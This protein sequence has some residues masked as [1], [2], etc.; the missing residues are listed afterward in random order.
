VSPFLAL[1]VVPA[2]LSAASRDLPDMRWMVERAER[3]ER[4][5]RAERV[6]R[7]LAWAAVAR[8]YADDVQGTEN[9]D[10]WRFVAFAALARLDAVAAGMPPPHLS[11][12]LPSAPPADPLG[13]ALAIACGYAEDGTPGAAIISLGGIAA[14]LGLRRGDII[15]AAD[16]VSVETPGDLASACRR[17][18]GSGPQSLALADGRLLGLS[19][20][21]PGRPVL[22]RWSLA[23]HGSASLQVPAVPD[24]WGVAVSAEAAADIRVAGFRAAKPPPDGWWHSALAPGERTT[25]VGI[26]G[27]ATRWRVVA[28]RLRP[29]AGWL[30]APPEGA[31]V[32]V[33]VSGGGWSVIAWAA[34][35]PITVKVAGP[36]G[37]SW[38][39]RSTG[40]VERYGQA[41]PLADAAI[42]A[43]G[44][45][46]L[47]IS[48]RGSAPVLVAWRALSAPPPAGV[49][50]P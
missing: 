30:L 25:T 43:T 47:T 45:A 24:G 33:P 32:R 10:V 37:V 38:L 27:T 20:A 14:A 16:G 41:T 44:S 9:D 4:D 46:L 19:W 34:E 26:A 3:I 6:H 2:A 7:V 50:P 29:L 48:A 1:L 28:Q 17:R 36:D 13:A 11:D 12:P 35:A 5:P 23:G 31:G 15:V 8:G 42:P 40:L 18:P 49:A 21:G 22:E 39:Q